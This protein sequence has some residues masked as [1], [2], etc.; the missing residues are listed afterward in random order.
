MIVGIA[1]I[2]FAYHLYLITETL[3]VEPY[4]ANYNISASIGVCGIV[5][6]LI[7]LLYGLLSKK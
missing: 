5:I 6:F 1:L 2:G 4:Y 3:S 7:I